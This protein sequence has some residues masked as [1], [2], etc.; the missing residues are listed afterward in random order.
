MFRPILLSDEEIDHLIEVVN[1]L[2]VRSW[3]DIYRKVSLLNRLVEAKWKTP[4]VYTG[5][6]MHEE[7]LE[8]MK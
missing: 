4:V 7:E 5:K 6:S 3:W 2:P 1:L 8:H